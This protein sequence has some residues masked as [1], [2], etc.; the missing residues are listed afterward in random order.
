MIPASAPPEGVLL[1]SSPSQPTRALRAIVRV[2]VSVSK[3]ERF[4]GILITCL[5]DDLSLDDL[6][7]LL[8]GKGEG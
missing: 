7:R 3:R 8:K 1:G 6:S 4:E 5:L 2:T